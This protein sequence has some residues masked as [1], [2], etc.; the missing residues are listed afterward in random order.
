M[1]TL[2]TFSSTLVVSSYA[3]GSEPGN[4]AD[5]IHISCV[6]I[7]VTV[8]FLRILYRSLPDMA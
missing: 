3:P 5:A 2:G 8:S 7:V 4:V 6:I 1:F